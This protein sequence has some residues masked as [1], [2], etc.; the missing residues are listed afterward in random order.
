MTRITSYGFIVV[1]SLFILLAFA[2][3]SLSQEERNRGPHVE[4]GATGEDFI[5]LFDADK[6]GKI[7][8][9]EW[10]AVKPTTVYRKKHWP[11]YDRN[12]DRSITLDEAPLPADPAE[13]APPEE[14]KY[15]VSGKQIA[16]I[17]K[18]DK[19]KDLKVSE[20]E[21]TGPNFSTYDKN[22]DGFIEPHEA[23]KN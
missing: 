22:G 2:T 9:N 4:G 15:R 13:A 23:P 20:K 17:A 21:Y 10:E 12:R 6:D 5:S 18:Y 1:I 19:D 3:Y 8:H 7:S 14:K 16:F 11:E